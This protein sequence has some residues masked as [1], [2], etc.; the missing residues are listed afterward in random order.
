MKLSEAPFTGCSPCCSDNR[1]RKD[2][3]RVCLVVSL[4]IHLAAI[5]AILLASTQNINRSPV[6]Y[7]DMNSIAD[8]APLATPVIHA[9]APRPENAELEQPVSEPEKLADTKT[10]ATGTPARSTSAEVMAT[11]LTRGMASGYF[12]SFAEG[13]NLRDD[14]REYYFMLLEKINS[15]WWL[16][17]ETLK[18]TALHDGIMLFVISRDGTLIELKLTKSTGSREVD[19]AIMAMLKDMS[20]FPELPANY[21]PDKFLAPLKIAAPLHLFSV[22][23]PR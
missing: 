15:S 9:P 11:S 14:I 7:I 18:E 23:N 2:V 4:S 6:T 20:P 19:Q 22:R 1:P 17:A 16:K 13:K 5:I 3:V 12:S 10:E 21:S 8:S